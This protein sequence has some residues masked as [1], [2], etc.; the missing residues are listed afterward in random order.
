M[1]RYSIGLLN[2]FAAVGLLA[3][4]YMCF[5]YLLT[6]PFMFLLDTIMVFL[7][8][9]GAIINLNCKIYCRPTC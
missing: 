4:M 3:V 2:F 5:D 1:F 7:N 8:L 6:A 9:Y